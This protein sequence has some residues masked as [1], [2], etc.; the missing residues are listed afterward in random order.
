MNTSALPLPPARPACFVPPEAGETLS[1]LGAAVTVKLGGGAADMTV[2]DH[3]VPVGFGV[4]MHLHHDEDEVCY[5]LE[6]EITFETGS[7]AQTAGPG[8][9]VRLPRGVAH[10]FRNA[11]GEPARMLVVTSPGGQLQA[12]MRDLDEAAATAKGPLAAETVGEIAA[13]RDV[14]FV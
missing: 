13:R 11:S 1:V 6:G 10:A 5:V 9:L 12:L 8:T 3:Q 7:A 14:W 4:P 2:V